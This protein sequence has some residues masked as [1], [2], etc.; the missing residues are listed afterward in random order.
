MAKTIVKVGDHLYAEIDYHHNQDELLVEFGNHFTI[1]ISKV[2]SLGQWKVTDATDGQGND[3]YDQLKNE[4]VEIGYRPHL[5]ELRECT[6]RT[7]FDPDEPLLVMI[8]RTG[9]PHADEYHVIEEDPF[10]SIYHTMT[11]AQIKDKY[12]I[13]L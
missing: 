4:N 12:K 2:N 13:E 6:F 7:F 9:H 3:A 10:E 5:G 1:Q 8:K 11:G